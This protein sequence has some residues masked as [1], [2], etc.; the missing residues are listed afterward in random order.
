MRGIDI[1]EAFL[2][3]FTVIIEAF[4]DNPRSCFSVSFSH[5]A[6]LLTEK[7]TFEAIFGGESQS[8]CIELGSIRIDTWYQSRSYH[9]V[10]SN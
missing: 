3:P 2:D 7:S 4:I 10:Y 1:F 8:F 9:S 5:R 6:I